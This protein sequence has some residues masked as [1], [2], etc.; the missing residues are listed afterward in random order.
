MHNINQCMSYLARLAS[1]RSSSDVW[2]DRAWADHGHRDVIW[3][4]FH[5]Q[6]M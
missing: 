1:E 4:H 5:W 2:E 6:T 3:S